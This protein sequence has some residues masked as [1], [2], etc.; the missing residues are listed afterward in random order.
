M[1]CFFFVITC[2]NTPTPPARGI[3][4]CTLQVT[5]ICT[6]TT[7]LRP[8]TG[9]LHCF[10]FVCC[11]SRITCYALLLGSSFNQFDTLCIISENWG[12]KYEF[13]RPWVNAQLFKILLSILLPVFVYFFNNVALFLLFISALC[14]IWPG[15][16]ILFELNSHQFISVCA[17]TRWGR[18]DFIFQKYACK[19]TPLYSFLLILACEQQCLAKLHT[20][21]TSSCISAQSGKI[22]K[23]VLTACV[24]TFSE[25]MPVYLLNSY[26]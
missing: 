19:H 7:L 8:I 23:R 11:L 24:A 13:F 1:F 26:K 6:T 21:F 16:K 15:K 22:N 10:A 14:V 18:N 3:I 17:Y 4:N 9:V 5:F 2:N 25:S 12:K 20:D